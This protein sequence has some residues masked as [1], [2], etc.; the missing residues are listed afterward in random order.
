M[1]F[2]SGMKMSVAT[3]GST[4]WG[5]GGDLLETMQGMGSQSQCSDAGTTGMELGANWPRSHLSLLS[6]KTSLFTKD[7]PPGVNEYLCNVGKKGTRIWKKSGKAIYPAL[8]AYLVNLFAL[9][10]LIL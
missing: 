1:G 3:A 5:G 4:A 7:R 6:E 9:H 10:N 2:L 8:P